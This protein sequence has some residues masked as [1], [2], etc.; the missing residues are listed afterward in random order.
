MRRKNNR[1][2]QAAEEYAK[3]FEGGYYETKIKPAI[4]AGVSREEIILMLVNSEVKDTNAYN[5]AMIAL[6]ERDAKKQK[7]G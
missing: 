7:K 1:V 6:N 5:K 4:D 2:D 3:F